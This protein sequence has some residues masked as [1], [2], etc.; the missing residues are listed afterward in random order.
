MI[1]ALVV[2]NITLLMAYFIVNVLAI[3]GLPK[4]GQVFVIKAMGSSLA[5]PHLSG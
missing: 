3:F 4:L 2:F 5:S 1:L